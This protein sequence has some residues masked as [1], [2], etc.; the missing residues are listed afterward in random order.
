MNPPGL[1]TMV[2]NMGGISNGWKVKV[3][4]HGALELGQQLG[5]AFGQLAAGKDDPTLGAM[6]EIE[7]VGDWFAAIPFRKG[8][9]P[10]SIAP[11]F[12]DYFLT[13]STHGR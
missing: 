12:E 1:K 9:N 2:V 3:R 6:L 5:W 13:M 4:N 7:T 10:L 8:L 11:N